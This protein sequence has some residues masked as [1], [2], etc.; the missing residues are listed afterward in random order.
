MH[1]HMYVLEKDEKSAHTQTQAHSITHK[2]ERMGTCTHTHTPHF[3]TDRPI[4]Y[5]LQKSNRL[6]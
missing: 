4:A 1:A 3:Q 5:Y 2:H 6:N